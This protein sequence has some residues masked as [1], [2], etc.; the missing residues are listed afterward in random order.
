LL[1][2]GSTLLYFPNKAQK[3]AVG[4]T[5]LYLAGCICPEGEAAPFFL[6]KGWFS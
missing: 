6:Y 2:A 5:L 3:F 4:F 1:P